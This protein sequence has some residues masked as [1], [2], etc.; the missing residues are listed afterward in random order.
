MT[1]DYNAEAATWWLKTKLKLRDWRMSNEDQET[2]IAAV[3]AWGEQIAAEGRADDELQCQLI[4]EGKAEIDML[5]S[6]LAAA[7]EEVGSLAHTI[8]AARV[9]AEALIKALEDLTNSAEKEGWDSGADADFKVYAYWKARKLLAKIREKRSPDVKNDNY[10]QKR[11]K[12]QLNRVHEAHTEIDKQKALAAAARETALREA[13]Y[14]LK[15]NCEMGC[16]DAI[17]AKLGGK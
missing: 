3:A 9:D 11:C 13:L 12:E 17:A 5:R 7:L 2:L 15:G 4:D 1:R 10:W 6:D 14:S 8:Q 16:A